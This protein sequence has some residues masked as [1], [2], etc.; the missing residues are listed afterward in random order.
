MDEQNEP[1]WL[2]RSESVPGYTGLYT[3]PTPCICSFPGE[4]EKHSSSYPLMDHQATLSESFRLS[5]CNVKLSLL[6]PVQLCGHVYY[7]HHVFKAFNALKITV[8]TAHTSNLILVLFRQHFIWQSSS[9]C[10]YYTYYSNCNNWVID[11]NITSFLGKYTKYT[12]CKIKCNY[13]KLSLL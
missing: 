11:T 4:K 3:T 1:F 7:I 9:A 6:C 5:I 13:Y 2:V 12:Y 10:T 8:T